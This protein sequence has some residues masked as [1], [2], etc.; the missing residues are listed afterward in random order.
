M[1]TGPYFRLPGVLCALAMI[2]MAAA[3]AG[4]QAALAPSA[5]NPQLS[6]ALPPLPNDAGQPRTA[7]ED[8]ILTKKGYQTFAQSS[9]ATADGDN[10]LLATTEE[11]PLEWGVYVFALNTKIP[12]RFTTDMTVNSGK[13]WLALGNYTKGMWEYSG[14]YDAASQDLPTVPAA[15]YTSPGGNIYLA[16]IAAR[17]EGTDSDLVV[18]TV[19]LTVGSGV[20]P[21]I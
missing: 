5:D 2:V 19:S 14:P 3:C 1:L 12:R 4:S 10:L 15:D 21:G 20:S 6:G 9:G 18:K 13:Y 8:S 16:I 7:S 17:A 11:E